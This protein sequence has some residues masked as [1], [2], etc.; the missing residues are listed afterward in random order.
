[1]KVTAHPLMVAVAM[2]LLGPVALTDEDHR[3]DIQEDKREQS[4]DEVLAALESEEG[5]VWAQLTLHDA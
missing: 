4:E 2:G 3:E 1:M 5:P